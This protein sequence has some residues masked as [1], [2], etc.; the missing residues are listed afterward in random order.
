MKHT[1]CLGRAWVQKLLKSESHPFEERN[2]LSP[3]ELVQISWGDAGSTGHLAG[4][5]LPSLPPTAPLSSEQE[6]FPS[7]SPTHEQTGGSIHSSE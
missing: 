7:A 1:V 5:S 6:T 4:L 2:S 3:Q